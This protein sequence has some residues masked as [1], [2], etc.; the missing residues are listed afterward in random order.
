MNMRI[1][2][3]FLLIFISISLLLLFN[4]KSYAAS[5][6]ISPNKSTVSP[7]ESITV[8]VTLS[9][10]A[11]YI[12][13]GGQT[14]W[15]DNS[16]FTYTTKAGN[17][18]SVSLSAS[19]VVADYNTE[20]DQN[21]SASAS[22][23]INAPAQS[24][25][26]ATN[27]NNSGGSSAPATSTPPSSGN[28]SSNNS[29]PTVSA[30]TLSNLGITPHDFSGFTSGRTS[31]TVNVPNDCTS[32]NVYASSKNGSVSGTGS[33]RLQEGTNRFNVTVSN[34]AG[35]K[36]YSI[37]VIRAGE[38]GED[39]PNVIDEPVEEEK[40]EGIGL[41]TLEI[42]GYTLD[43]EFKTDQYSYSI[44]VSNEITQEFVDSLKEKVKAT[45]NIENAEVEIIPAINEE[46]KAIITIIVKDS[47]KEYARY[48]VNIENKE[49]EEVVEEEEN[50]NLVVGSISNSSSDDSGSGFSIRDMPY[51]N[52]M[53]IILGAY[54]IT[55]L[56]AVGFAFIA[57]WKS[58]ELKEYESEE[59]ED[60]REYDFKSITKNEISNETS[61]ASEK[62]EKISGYRSLK[63]G[64]QTSGRHF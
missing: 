56:M 29:K 25:A 63:N 4:I 45:A 59:V 15:L 13:A 12:T 16:S 22:V 7:G 6:S 50:D 20:K 58:K 43:K 51:K 31:Y 10:G 49:E 46:G 8:T 23:K 39:V 17:S 1:K 21:V 32:I 54:C 47:E 34:S 19:G 2:K 61:I 9:N 26:P 42:E 55:F 38:S 44:K 5:L 62:M 60:N 27:T 57:Y 11:G 41:S 3:Y 36:T 53:Y 48:N 40:T 30:P 18:G 33:K 64:K 28:S 37:S 52:K 14:N 24:S 35:S